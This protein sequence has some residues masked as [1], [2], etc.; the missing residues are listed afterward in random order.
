MSFGRRLAPL[1]EKSPA[2]AIRQG[3][4][5]TAGRLPSEAELAETMGFVQAQSASY[6]SAG[7]AQAR[8][9]AWADFAQVLMSLNEFIYV[10]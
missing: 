8:E 1:A 4:L 7:Q 10:E 3:Y 2:D 6:Q 5:A 9:L